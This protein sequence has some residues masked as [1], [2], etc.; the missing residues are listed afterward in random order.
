MGSDITLKAGFQPTLQITS[1][2]GRLSLSQL[3]GEYSALN[4]GLA[5]GAH[6]NV[7]PYCQ[8]LITPGWGEAV[9]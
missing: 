1:L 7:L 8:V 9:V 2:A 4:M 5:T 3:P 6:S